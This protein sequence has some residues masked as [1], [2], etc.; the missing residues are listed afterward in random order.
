MVVGGDRQ[1]PSSRGP[2]CSETISDFDDFCTIRKRGISVFSRRNNHQNPI[3][4]GRV[5]GGSISR[6]LT[7][8]SSSSL[9]PQSIPCLPPPRC[10]TC[11]GRGVTVQVI[12]MGPMIQQ[13]QAPCQRRE[14]G[15]RGQNW[16]LTVH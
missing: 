12:R 4:H 11:S 9:P 2:Y 16:E 8:N 10:P 3:R 15:E 6:L 13:Q 5:V 7:H 1:H 14:A